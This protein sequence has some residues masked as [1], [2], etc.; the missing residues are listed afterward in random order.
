MN[1]EE[2]VALFELYKESIVEHSAARQA[3]I[4]NK[5]DAKL[6]DEMM[7]QQGKK[8]MMQQCISEFIG[9]QEEYREWLKGQIV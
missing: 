3:Y 9:G 1:K 5:K 6:R 8:A 7:I 2:K 4:K